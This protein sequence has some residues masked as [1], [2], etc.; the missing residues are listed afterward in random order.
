MNL[1][2]KTVDFLYLR[3]IQIRK[4]KDICLKIYDCNAANDVIFTAS[5][6][7]VNLPKRGADHSPTSSAE[8]AMGWNYA[9]LLYL[10]R[11]VIG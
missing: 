11:N 2:L 9:T 1:T 4:S 6:P 3:N 10:H 5:F 8:G 7:E